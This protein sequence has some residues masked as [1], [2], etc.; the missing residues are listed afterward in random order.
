MTAGLRHREATLSHHQRN[1]RR[2]HPGPYKDKGQGE[3]MAQTP[4]QRIPALKSVAHDMHIDG[5]RGQE[6]V[7]K[8][9]AQSPQT[10]QFSSE[11]LGPTLIPP[12]LWHRLK[13]PHHA[14]VFVL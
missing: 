14:V 5:Q 13:W 1:H 10:A 9:T 2:S 11:N 6:S 3:E 7:T 4:N 12:V 8:I